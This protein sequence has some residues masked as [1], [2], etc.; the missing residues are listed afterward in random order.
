MKM[1]EVEK[2]VEDATE[3]VTEPEP[4]PEPLHP[5]HRIGAFLRSRGVALDETPATKGQANASD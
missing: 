3:V 2:A 1:D 4:E 5:I